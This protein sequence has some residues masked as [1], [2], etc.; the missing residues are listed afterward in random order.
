MH[1]YFCA[2]DSHVT[3]LFLDR[4][5]LV[6]STQIIGF[7]VGGVARRFLVLPPSM[8]ESH[9]VLDR[10]Y[11][12]RLRLTFNPVWPQNL[13]YSALFNT[14]HAQQLVGA[15]NRGG[16]S[17]ERFFTYIFIFATFWYFLPGYLFTALSYFSWVC[18][19][20]PTNI[21]GSFLFRLLWVDGN[22][23]THAESKP[24]VRLW[25]WARN[26]CS[27]IWLGPNHVHC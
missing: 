15:G 11:L 4:W 18:W 3:N 22:S 1:W 7:S 13:V 8:S 2:P 23:L 21:V 24:I 17:R 14:L 10:A 20:A 19:I 16:L 25:K 6:I 12:S 5:L 27:H 26:V 9:R